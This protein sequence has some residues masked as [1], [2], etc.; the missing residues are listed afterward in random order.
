MKIMKFPLLKITLFFILGIVI[1]NYFKLPSHIIFA[2]SLAVLSLI[3]LL[4]FASKRV[5]KGLFIIGIAVLLFS[6]ILGVITTILHDEQLNPSHFTN[7][8]E[9]FHQE[10]PYIVRIKEKSKSTLKYQ[11]YIAEITSINHK[12]SRGK[13]LI[14]FKKDSLPQI[15][16]GQE[17]YLNSPIF[18]HKN[19][20]NPN[21]FNYG[22]YLKKQ[23][24]Y[25]QTYPKT[26]NIKFTSSIK[27]DSYYYAD[28]IRNKFLKNLEATGF[29]PDELQV[30]IALLLGQQQDINPEIIKDYQIAGAVH[31]LSVSGLH[32]GF[33]MLFIGFLLQPLPNTLWGKT[34]KIILILASLWIFALLAGFSPSV[35]R[36][37]AMYSFIAIA[38]YYNRSKNIYHSLI[39][40]LLVILLCNPSFLFDIG[41]QLSYSAVFFIVWL[42]PQMM[43]LWQPKN[44]ILFYF[45]QIITVSLAAQIGTFPL[46]IYYFHQFPTLFLITNV[47]VIPLLG[48]IMI[49][50][51]I[52]LLLAVADILPVFIAKVLEFLVQALNEIIH[53]VASFEAFSI[54]NI[55]FNTT[56]LVAFYVLL[57]SFVFWLKKPVMKNGIVVAV[58][59]LSLQC[60]FLYIK[61]QQH[62]RN[63]WVVF[64]VSKQ[65][66]LAHHH[67]SKTVIYTTE[68]ETL[69]PEINY[70]LHS[71][72]IGNFTNTNATQPIQSVYYI[73]NSRILVIDSLAV[74]PKEARP[75][76]VVLIQS[77]KI[78]L[79]RML[80]ELQPKELVVDASNYKTY[81]NSW[82]MTCNQKKIPFH[83]TREKGF[84]VLKN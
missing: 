36:S 5:N 45:W 65:S 70:V 21:Q 50:G 15:S 16:I 42:Q 53:W 77:P 31:I 82:K 71:Y 12:K 26:D 24:I 39:V 44:K 46:S 35:V 63:E 13:L 8:I 58:S 60:T 48:I 38:V 43:K 69:T 49:L 30:V 40:S 47:L 7:V 83:Y 80:D 52:V 1:G 25:G 4:H 54:Q 29:R 55:P 22:N 56:M 73:N 33:I 74:Y 20:T 72:L 75:D 41:F 78:N 28:N 34:V 76:I 66:L 3:I 14:N 81:V 17:I 27:K 59:I 19:P 84:Y 37:V 32:V 9:D 64:D 57:I 10:I 51:V 67:P 2:L 6:T 62:H 23:S 68:P 79:E 61:Y 18:L 11:K